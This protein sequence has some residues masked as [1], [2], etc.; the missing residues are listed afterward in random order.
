MGVS[1]CQANIFKTA[2]LPETKKYFHL[3]KESYNGNAFEYLEILEAQ[4][5][6]VETKKRYVESLKTLQESVAKLERLCSRH[7]HG[8]KGDVF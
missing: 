6:L 1:A 5:T 3:T 4:R 8:S 7:F 2:I